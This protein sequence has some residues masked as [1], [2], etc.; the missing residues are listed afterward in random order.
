MNHGGQPES[1]RPITGSEMHFISDL[2]QTLYMMNA[3]LKAPNSP[4]L[5]VFSSNFCTLLGPTQYKEF[6]PQCKGYN[7]FIMIIVLDLVD[8]ARISSNLGEMSLVS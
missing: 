7:F 4:T 1:P 8:Q 2:I 3:P 5:G 6:V